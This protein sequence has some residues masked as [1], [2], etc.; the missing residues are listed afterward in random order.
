MKE[1]VRKDRFRERKTITKDETTEHVQRTSR[2]VKEGGK[3]EKRK[4]C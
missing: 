1:R 3:V 2:E 4:W